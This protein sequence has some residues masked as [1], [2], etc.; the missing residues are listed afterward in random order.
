MERA[1]AFLEIR[2]RAVKHA[3]LLDRHLQGIRG[4]LGAHGFQSL[5]DARRADEERD[6]AIVI[7][8]KARVFPRTR[9][10]AFD[11]ATDGD[12]VVAARDEFSLQFLLFSP[13]ELQ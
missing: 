6:A 10:A 1:E 9:C 11:E 2:R 12:A 5:A 7:E 13:T 3:D 8:R 4:D